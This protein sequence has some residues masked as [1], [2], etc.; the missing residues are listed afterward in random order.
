MKMMVS[1]MRIATGAE[2]PDRR[3]S[4]EVEAVDLS[5]PERAWLGESLGVA[6]SRVWE[7]R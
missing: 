7:R 5:D 2:R 4:G 6:F 1:R 3:H